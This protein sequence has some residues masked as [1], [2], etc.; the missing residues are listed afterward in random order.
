LIYPGEVTTYQA[1][2][3]DPWNYMWIGFHGYRSTEMT[4]RAG[5]SREKPVMTCRNIDEI[6]TAMEKLLEYSE[7]S[8]VNELLRM[9]SLY[10]LMALLTKNAGEGRPNLPEEGSTDQ[11]YVK[12][13][14]NLLINSQEKNVKVADVASAIGISRTYLTSIFKKEMK[15]SPQTFLMNFRM[16]R[17][18]DYLRYT[19]RPVGEIA[20]EVGYADSMAFSKAFKKHFHLTPSE[21]RRLKPELAS[22]TIKG[23]FTSEHPL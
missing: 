9:S 11:F 23:A 2:E 8:Y 14:I 16:E 12:T 21:F 1:D 5:F 10:Q 17:A 7:L 13:A 22:L 3:K 15:V 6:N 4:Q 20:E 18:G 19:D